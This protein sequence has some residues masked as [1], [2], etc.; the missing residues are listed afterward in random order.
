M[1]TLSQYR[2]I[3]SDNTLPE[4]DLSGFIRMKVKDIKKMKVVP[5]GPLP[6]DEIDDEADVLYAASESDTGGLQIS[7]C[8][9]PPY[10]LEDYISK[11]HIY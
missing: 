1:V 3:A 11:S 5:R 6:W 8:K 9:N 4:I 10:G 2:F 7:T